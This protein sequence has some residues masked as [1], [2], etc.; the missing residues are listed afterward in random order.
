MEPSLHGPHPIGS[1]GILNWTSF[2][3]GGQGMYIPL[4]DAVVNRGSI[5]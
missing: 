4:D 3:L 5:S 2:A 1:V